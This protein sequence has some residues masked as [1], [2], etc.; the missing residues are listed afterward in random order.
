MGRFS[1][2]PNRIPIMNQT[3]KGIKQWEWL[4]VLFASTIMLFLFSRIARTG[5]AAPQEVITVNYPGDIIA[6][7]G[8]CS[9][10][11]AITAANTDT[12]SGTLPGEC[13]AGN[14]TDM[15]IIDNPKPSG[16]L[17]VSRSGAFEDNNLTGD[18]DILS[19]LTIQGSTNNQN[20][21]LVEGQIDRAFDIFPGNTVTFRYIDIIGGVAPNDGFNGEQGGG[22]RNQGALTLINTILASN[23]TSAGSDI[24]LPGREAG[25]M[26]VPFI[27]GVMG[28]LLR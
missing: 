11:E 1:L 5:K 21:I 19:S 15:I 6:D 7:D 8:F 2:I 22:I 10:R 17:F 28:H 27:P 14:G 25:G 20:V 23:R 18:L 4:V 13:V 24:D 9:L 26:G 16:F 12:P 3:N